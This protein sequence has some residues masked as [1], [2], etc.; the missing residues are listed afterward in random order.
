MKKLSV[1]RT[2]ISKDLVA[3]LKNILQSL[4]KTIYVAVNTGYLEN[5]NTK[6]TT[7]TKCFAWTP[8]FNTAEKID[9]KKKLTIK[10]KKN[11]A[12]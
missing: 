10:K 4:R 7:A 11:I 12:N 9:N 3:G 8:F 5:N 2:W 6:N 1:K